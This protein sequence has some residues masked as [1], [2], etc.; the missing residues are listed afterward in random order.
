M[1]QPLIARLGARHPGAAVDALAPEW[2]APVYG[3]MPG[4]SEVIPHRLGHGHLQWGERRR[5]A[6]GLRARGYDR[7]FVLPNSLKSALIPWLAGVPGR[8][9]FVGE[10]RRGLLNDARRL[11]P[12]ALPRMVERFAALAEPPGAATP[13][14]PVPV[15]RAEPAAVR[16]TLG[17]LAAGL[18]AAALCVGAEYGPAKRWPVE[19]FAALA[20]ALR[21]S[22]FEVWL[23]GSAKDAELGQA[24]AGRADCHDFCGRTTLAEAVHLLAA[25][26]LAVCNDSGLMHVA[27]A[28][29]TPLVALYGSSSPGFTP[30]LSDRARVLTLNLPCSPCF[31][32]EC[33]LGHFECLR[34]LTPERV[35]AD[36]DALPRRPVP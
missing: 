16:A 35:L 15:L 27:A 33:P 28:V 4:V 25:A 30:P 22:G 6:A 24:V 10:F 31:Q 21:A 26:S 1:S 23:L 20:V 11:D 17:R 8:T 13:R 34:G 14:P 3:L 18:P 5:L 29:G 19:H 32:R 7:A 36:V 12:A 9:G 2:V